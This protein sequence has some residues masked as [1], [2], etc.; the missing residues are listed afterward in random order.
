[1]NL[2][3][4]YNQRLNKVRQGSN[5]NP[6][7]QWMGLPYFSYPQVGISLLVG[8]SV[9]IYGDEL[10]NVPI[11]NNLNV[12]YTCDIGIQ[13]DNNLILNPEVENV[14]NHA[15]IITFKN[16][17]RIINTYTIDLYVNVKAETGAVKILRI[18]DSLMLDGYSYYATKLNTILPG[19]TFT[20]L[21]TLGTTT[22]HEGYG[23]YRFV[24][25]ATNSQP[26]PFFKA[27]VLDIAAYFTDNAIDTPD[28]VE[29]NL[30]INDTFLHSQVGG[31]G[32]TDAEILAI[33]NHAKTFINALLDYNANFRIILG[34]PTLC[35]NSGAGWNT[36]YDET[37]YSQDRYIENMNKYRLAF[38]S[39]FANQAYNSR[40]DC[41]YET[42]FLDRNDG[43]PKTNNIHTNGVHPDQSG[44]EQLG[45]GQAI[46]IN[47]SILTPKL[48]VSWID[49]YAALTWVNNA[50]VTA[51]YEIY[52]SVNGGDYTLVSTTD[53][54]AE[55]YNNYTYQNANINFKVRA[56]IGTWYSDFS[57]V[58]NIVTPLVWKTNQ[59]TLAN[60]VIGTLNISVGK[61]ININWGDGTNANYTGDNANITKTYTSTQDP[62][63]IQLSGDLN[64][65]TRFAHQNQDA[66]YGDISKWHI[67]IPHFTLYHNKHTGNI[68]NWGFV[69]NGTYIQIGHNLLTGDLSSWIVPSTM[70]SINLADPEGSAFIGDLSGWNLPEGLTQLYLY[71]QDFTKLP[72]GAYKN[73]NSSVGYYAANNNC[74]SD[75]IDSLLIDINSYFTSISPI[76]NSLFNLGGAGMGIPS[77]V[78][79]AARD[80]IIAK[81]T[82][83][84]FTATVTVNS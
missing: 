44:Y 71:Y 65:I 14:G 31:N 64:F 82:A 72:R 67:E 52:E 39:A 59:S 48:I 43:Y 9:T 74:S 17:T 25:F 12:T 42:M 53:A 46:A 24:D 33:I 75:E 35:E 54:G 32:L 27:G 7:Y 69:P 18:G 76:K 30:G 81:Y 5:V 79:L 4:E 36:N 77:A 60:V 20:Y 37:V 68:S 50:G 40:V 78:G 73:I 34:I 22:K 2:L 84:G 10:I 83:A 47:R 26:T 58:I 70:T 41:S 61:T 56:K 1:M 19:V 6:F 21:G 51:V 8:E 66:S 49:D 11:E 3:L 13:S 80:G 62:Y 57:A 45:T 63:Y 29:I 15:C 28:V 38:V 55:S 16:G 23:G